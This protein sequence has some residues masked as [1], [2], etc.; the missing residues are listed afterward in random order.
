MQNLNSDGLSLWALIIS[1]GSFLAA[2]ISAI[3]TAFQWNAA[4]DSAKSSRQSADA[5]DETV[6]ISKQTLQVGQRS[7]LTVVPD[8]RSRHGSQFP[9]VVALALRN[10]GQTP[11][12]RVNVRYAWSIDSSFHEIHGD[13]ANLLSESLGTIGPGQ[14]ACLSVEVVYTPETIRMLQSNQLRL[15]LFG[16]AMFED[17]F[18]NPHHT[19]WCLTYN[20]S[21]QQLGW[22]SAG[23]EID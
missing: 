4:R 19:N 21:T 2:V 13:E 12:K 10:G 3:F 5:A 8:V 20:P 7:W 17:I 22:H 16:T 18:G 23:N 15:Y 9:S 6:K 11:A 1:I 14:E